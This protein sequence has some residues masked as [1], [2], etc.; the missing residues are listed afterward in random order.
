M[1]FFSAT[2]ATSTRRRALAIL[3]SCLVL[4]VYIGFL[5]VSNYRSQIALR[6]STMERFRLDAEKRAASLGYFFSERKYDLRSLAASREISTYFNNKSLGMSE[7]YGL[8]VSIFVI[9]QMLEKT[10][11]DKSIQGDE[12]YERFLFLDSLGRPLIDTA[13]QEE[14]N[15]SVTWKKY[16]TSH[17]SDP[18]VFVDA[19]EGSARI[20]LVA[21][22]FYRNEFEGELI[23]WL[24]LST[25]FAYW[26]DLSPN[27]SRK[28]FF[29]ADVDGRLICPLGDQACRNEAHFAPKQLVQIPLEGFSTF[30]FASSNGVFQEMVGARLRSPTC[31]CISSPGC[32]A[33]GFM[34]LSHPGNSLWARDPWLW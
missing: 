16:L 17:R 10:I 1:R 3:G 9:G 25:L 23:A 12:I 18:T 27:L 24:N 20:L 14:G 11:L 29:L 33:K 2:W 34:D 26:V 7:Q 8:K 32:R 5:M 21:P 30:R 15:Q 19:E 13:P 22:C 28:D 31:L 4:V 6:E